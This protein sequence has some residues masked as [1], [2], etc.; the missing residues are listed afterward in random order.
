MALAWAEYLSVG[1]AMIDSEH[2]D[3]II[4]VNNVEHAIE[5][6]DRDALSKSFDLLDS[7]MHNHFR[8]EEMI[9]EA[10]NFPFAQ[11]KLEHRHLLREMKYMREELETVDGVWPDDL[12]RKYH[13]F[14]SGWMTDHIVREDMQFKPELESHPY[15]FKPG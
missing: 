4:A 5:T 6:G 11:N 8:S 12:V 3:L 15:D 1:N 7:R 10:A 9:A 13:R 2:K 14:L